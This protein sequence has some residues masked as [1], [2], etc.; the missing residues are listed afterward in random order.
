MGLARDDLRGLVADTVVGEPAEGILRAAAERQSACIVMCARTSER[1]DQAIGSTAAAVLVAAPCPVVL[2]P[3]R[4]R[5][6]PW[7]LRRVLLP[8]DGNPASA[9]AVRPATELAARA[10]ASLLVLHVAAPAEA[11]PV[12]P[13]TL[14]VPRYVDQPQH[15]WPAWTQEFLE[16]AASLGALPESLAMKLLVV[17]GEPGVEIRRAAAAR[18]IDL[19]VLSWSG[20]LEAARAATVKALISEAPTP[21]MM[22]RV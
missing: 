14:M 21:V 18:E 19:V 9:S 15:E 13:G 2:V 7:D 12:E 16:R 17:T 5:Q 10:N 3:P 11:P 4:R 8:F 22:L 6:V 20:R 1:P